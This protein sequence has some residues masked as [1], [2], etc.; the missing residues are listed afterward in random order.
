[1]PRAARV[2]SAIRHGVPAFLG[3]RG[4]VFLAGYPYPARDHDGYFQ[5]VRAVDALFEDRWRVYFDTAPLPGRQRWLD[6]PAARV[7]VLRPVGGRWR[8]RLAWLVLSACVLRCRAVWFHS[9]LR[10]GEHGL[11]GLLRRRLR[12]VL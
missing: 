3:M 6:R 7:L 1:R 9:V 11:V 12:P 4:V 2:L 8:E 10:M 5:R